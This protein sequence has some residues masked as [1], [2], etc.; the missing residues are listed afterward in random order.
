MGGKREREKPPVRRS[1]LG[2]G[3]PE[4]RMALQAAHG[5]GRRDFNELVRLLEAV[6]ERT[7]KLLV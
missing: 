7:L 2:P 6:M 5:I 3:A 1:G 4:F